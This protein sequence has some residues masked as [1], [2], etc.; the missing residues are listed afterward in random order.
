MVPNDNMQC[1]LLIMVSLVPKELTIL[2][3]KPRPV[4][5]LLLR[6]SWGCVPPITGQVTSTCGWL[7]IIWA[8]LEQ[9][10]ENRPRICCDNKVNPML[11]IW[12][13][14]SSG[15][16]QLWHWPCK[17]NRHLLSTEN[18]FNY[19]NDINVEKWEK[20]WISF[21]VTQLMFRRTPVNTLRPRQ[22]GPH[23]ADNIFK[24]IFFNENVW[25][26]IQI[27]LK[28]VP[29]G[30]IN[31]IPALF[32]IMTWRHPGNRPLSEAMLVSLLMHKY[33]TRPQGVNSRSHSQDC[34]ALGWW[35]IGSLITSQSYQG[36]LSHCWPNLDKPKS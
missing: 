8:Y 21:Y 24:R 15:H 10:T 6:V 2:V 12:L 26:L 5:S 1:D 3:L 9:E 33:V 36:T 29:K 25:I 32:Q 18:D 16:Q 28:F 4:F 23:F 11:P 14:I 35:K 27:S 22:N 30:P 34:L 20:T 19:L 17:I 13:L 7:S 31:K